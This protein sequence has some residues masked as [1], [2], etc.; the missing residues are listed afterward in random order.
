VCPPPLIH[1]T[2]ETDCTKSGSSRW[3]PVP[4]AG[5]KKCLNV[6]LQPVGDKDLT[7]KGKSS[8]SC[9]VA[10]SSGGVHFAILLMNPN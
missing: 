4:H 7:N 9:F 10:S 8:S 2:S 1:L 3:L 6:T 5:L